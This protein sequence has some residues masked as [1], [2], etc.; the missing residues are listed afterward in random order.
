MMNLDGQC[1]GGTDGEKYP[2]TTR[3]G[4]STK[5]KKKQIYMGITHIYIYIYIYYTDMYTG[6]HTYIKME[7]TDIH[8]TRR[9]EP[10]PHRYSQVG[11]LNL[12]QSMSLNL[13][14]LQL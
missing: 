5:T 9:T 8:T 10:Y 2:K 14:G 3:T 6:K 1:E 4:K 7:Q 11:N 13:I 12:L